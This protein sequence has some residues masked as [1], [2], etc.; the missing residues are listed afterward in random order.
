VSLPPACQSVKVACYGGVYPTLLPLFNVVKTG[1]P[2]SSE[3]VVKL[4]VPSPCWWVPQT[5]VDVVDYAD[6]TVEEVGSN[7]LVKVKYFSADKSATR[8]E[9]YVYPVKVW[10]RVEE[11]VAPLRE[12]RPP[13][14]PG[15]IF[16]GP[17]GT[18]KTSLLQILPDYLGLSTV[19]LTAEAVLSKWVG[20]TE[21]L[22]SSAFARAVD[23]EPSLIVADEGEWLLMP[24]A[25]ESGGYSDV[26][27]N[28]LGIVKRAL[29]D[30]YKNARRV[31]VAFSANVA[32]SSIDSTLKRNGRCGKPVVIPL[33]DK[34]AVYQYLTVAMRIPPETAERMSI[35]AVN[36]G[37]S[38]ADVVNMATL[39][40]ETGEYRV[41]P[42]RYR[43]YR[44]HF[45]PS[46]LL[47]DPDVKAF[48]HCLDENFDVTRLA[49]YP[50]TRVWIPRFKS[51]ITL[52]LISAALNLV[53][54]RPVVV[55][56][57]VRY[58]DE[59]VDMISLL[60]ATA[61]VLSNIHNEYA[62]RLWS[63]ADFPIVFVGEDDPGVEVHRV[64]I[65]HCIYKHREGVA[66]VIASAYGV[67][68]EDSDYKAFRSLSE[69]DFLSRLES[70][71][72]AGG[73]VKPFRR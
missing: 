14:N 37:L 32:E 61:I 25:S 50:R 17:P 54:V 63:T 51:A 2:V 3:C 27:R 60:G 9:F 72:L 46:K 43:G 40:L 59:A 62:K 58:I 11:R 36:A 42:M 20:E 5:E 4:A 48:L 15:V 7:Y 8:E 44:R 38:M 23:L 28:M 16:I 10:N 6:V 66:R 64:D 71:A 39:Y 22:L 53:A 30:Y 56:D 35:E 70:I 19:E 52:P 68:L 12:G 73:F 26:S 24:A 55:V 67:K 18:G 33:P 69:E 49:G 21:K 41:E 13:R 45:I 34:D 1:Q 29:S 57:D 65:T 31:L 47:A